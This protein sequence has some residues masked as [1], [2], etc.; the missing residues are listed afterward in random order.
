[1]FIFTTFTA[2]IFT[3]MLVKYSE[4]IQ[5][6]F[7]FYIDDNKYIEDDMLY[8]KHPMSDSEDESEIYSEDES[9]CE[10]DDDL[11]DFDE[12]TTLTDEWLSKTDEEKRIILDKEIDEYM[13][14]K[15]QSDEIES[16]LKDIKC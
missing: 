11:E 15:K 1:M 5:K 6:L 7:G 9:D 13:E 2:F 4:A 16:H 8:A 12:E 3:L 14:R 10:L